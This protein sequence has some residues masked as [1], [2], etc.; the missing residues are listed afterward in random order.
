[1]TTLTNG[2]VESAFQQDTEDVFLVLLTITHDDLTTP[3]RVVNNNEDITSR[4]DLFVAFPFEIILPDS[5]NDSSPR[6]RLVIDNV[7]AEIATA[8]RSITSAPLAAIEL[9]MASDPDT[10]EK[11]YTVFRL[12]NVQWTAMQM[13]AELIIEFLETEPYPALKF[14]PNYFPGLFY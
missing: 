2:F 14:T 1:M 6:S 12:H 13:S 11:S 3:I 5:K 4:G 9:I 8:I 7:T 10:V